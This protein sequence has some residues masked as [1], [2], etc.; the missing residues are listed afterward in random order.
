MSARTVRR[1]QDDDGGERETAACHALI[2]R[3]PSDPRQR[4]GQGTPPRRRGLPASARRPAG[5]RGASLSRRPRTSTR[6]TRSPRRPRQPAA[7]LRRW[8]ADARRDRAALVGC[9]RRRPRG[10]SPPAR[11]RRRGSSRSRSSSAGRRGRCGPRSGS[12]RQAGHMDGG[13]VLRH[14]R[15]RYGHVSVPAAASQRGSG[16]RDAR[17]TPDAVAL[18][19]LEPHARKNQ[20][21]PVN[22]RPDVERAQEEDRCW[23]VTI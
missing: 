23:C 19:K 13:S 10:S 8:P 18:A 5:G 20:A 2:V 7:T 3:A 16:A 15:F 12:L 4:A 17:S 6:R 22:S 1:S 9:C 11:P 14:G 21:R